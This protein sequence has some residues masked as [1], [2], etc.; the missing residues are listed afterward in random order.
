MKIQDKWK[1]QL[2]VDNIDFDYT[3]SGGKYPYVASI[4]FPDGKKISLRGKKTNAVIYL[5]ANDLRELEKC[6]SEQLMHF[7]YLLQFFLEFAVFK[8][9]KTIFINHDPLT[10]ILPLDVR[11]ELFSK[12]DFF[13]LDSVVAR[14]FHK[15]GLLYNNAEGWVM[16]SDNCPIF[17]LLKTKLT[18]HTFLNDFERNEELFSK[19][20]ATK[21]HSFSYHYYG[22][23]GT[24]YFDFNNGYV[25]LKEPK[26][27]LSSIHK[28]V[29]L[30]TGLD[31]FFTKIKKQLKIKSI[32]SDS[33]HYLDEYL[34]F[35][36]VPYGASKKIKHAVLNSHSNHVLEEMCAKALRKKEKIMFGERDIYLFM[37][38]NDVFIANYHD[39][40]FHGNSEKKGE[41]F[42]M[43]EKYILDE[44]ERVLN[45]KKNKLSEI[46]KNLLSR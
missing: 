28:F 21:L 10:K 9:A 46:K 7:K 27:D 33:T 43:F 22:H 38:G 3:P 45:Q 40:L 26:L 1:E 17:G 36:N 19:I 8:E 4:T 23:D 2:A 11:E 29:D 44:M 31:S 30:N 13:Y 39:I 41:A 42:Q 5:I 15:D 37:V 18:I 14:D 34:N 32:F 12:D 24:L 6:D 25:T 20:G 35:I 16:K